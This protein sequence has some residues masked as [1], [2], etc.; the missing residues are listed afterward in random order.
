[1]H[2]EPARTE[3][4]RQIYQL[5]N[6]LENTI[7]SFSAF[8]AT[9]HQL[10]ASE[11]DHLFVLRGPE[12]AGYIHMKLTPQLHHAAL[13]AEIQELVIRSDCRNQNLGTQLLYHAIDF[14]AEHCA[15]Q[16]ELTSNFSRPDAHR[17]YKKC[18]FSR[19]SYKF[20]YPLAVSHNPNQPD[21][22]RNG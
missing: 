2:I 20:V 18:G 5:T 22:E 16:V 14:A 8:E 10:I 9:F 19:T 6:E 15:E 17:F 1:M 21:E 12:P 3:D 11:Q 7:L 13:I 4:C